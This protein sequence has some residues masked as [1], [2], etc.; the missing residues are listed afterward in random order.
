MVLAIFLSAATPALAGDVECV[1]AEVPSSQR[2]RLLDA[3]VTGG[4]E[5]MVEALDLRA[6]LPD[7]TERCHFPQ[8]PEASRQAG[9]SVGSYAVVQSAARVLEAR[10]GPSWATL[11]AAWNE[12]A[13][14]DRERMEQFALAA[15]P[16]PQEM[17][18]Q[19]WEIAGPMMARAGWSG[20]P[21]EPLTDLYVDIYTS[22]AVS[23]ASARNW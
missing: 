22:L 9:I 17:I 5:A 10:G 4:R 18:T 8:D 7:F 12:L 2:N 1:W 3:Y 11:L 14:P 6:Q 13:P 23:R 21:S 15:S 20:D 19:W 16:H